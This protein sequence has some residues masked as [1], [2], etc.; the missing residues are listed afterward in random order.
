MH[1]CACVGGYAC[2]GCV[3]YIIKLNAQCDVLFNL[4]GPEIRNNHSDSVCNQDVVRV[5]IEDVYLSR[6]QIS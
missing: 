3:G 4:I 2:V 6:D 5:K 1:A